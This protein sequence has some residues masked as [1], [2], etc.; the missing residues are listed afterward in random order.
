LK[1]VID[2]DGIICTNQVDCNYNNAEPIQENID[3]INRLFEE[4]NFI[5]LFTARGYETGID[6]LMVTE[7]QMEKWKVDY[8]ELRFGK[9]SADFYIDDK[10]IDISEV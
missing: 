8:H 7:K 5:V 3:K 4:N 6:W 9:P 1:Y 2:I 10:F